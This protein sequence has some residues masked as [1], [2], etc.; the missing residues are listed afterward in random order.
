MGKL[1]KMKKQLQ[2]H[3]EHTRRV[4]QIKQERFDSK[5]QVNENSQNVKGLQK[6]YSTLETEHRKLF[7]E[8]LK[9][10]MKIQEQEEK[11]KDQEVTIK[12][13]Q[14]QRKCPEYVELSEDE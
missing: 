14:N 1:E 8:K 2:L 10:T 7:D 13:L 12:K 4:S 5:S 6:I 3:V 11:I 9:C